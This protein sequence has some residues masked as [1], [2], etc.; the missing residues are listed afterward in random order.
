MVKRTL[1]QPYD[2][3]FKVLARKQ[4][5]FRLQIGLQK[6]WVSIDRLK[7]AHILSDTTTESRPSRSSPVSST[8]TRS[9]RRVRFRL[10]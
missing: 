5:F 1:Q 4:K 9:G 2:G 6:K 3:P 8:T 7:P 10:P